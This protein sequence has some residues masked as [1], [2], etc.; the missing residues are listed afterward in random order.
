MDNVLNRLRST[1]ISTVGNTA[2]VVNQVSA[3]LPG[4]NVTKEYEVVKHIGSAGPGKSDVLTLIIRVHKT[5]VSNF[6][7]DHKPLQTFFFF[8]FLVY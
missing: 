1:L 4:N 3:A 8:L 7:L 5:S 2:Q 6:T